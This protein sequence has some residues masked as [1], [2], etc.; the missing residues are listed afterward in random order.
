M[1]SYDREPTFNLRPRSDQ[2]R[3][4]VDFWIPFG[5]VNVFKELCDVNNPLGVEAQGTFNVNN[6]DDIRVLKT[7]HERHAKYTT[8]LRGESIAQLMAMEEPRL[9]YFRQTHS[10]MFVNLVGDAFN[11]PEYTIE[12]SSDRMGTKVRLKYWFESV[13]VKGW[14]C[15][16]APC[17]G[18]VLHRSLQ[19]RAA[20]VWHHDMLSRGYKPTS[21]INAW[22]LSSRNLL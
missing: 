11:D 14:L 17:M 18:A 6:M 16:V 7:G 15:F 4:Q 10:N 12:L 22:G 20:S 9:L 19:A 21:S 3:F 5:Q 1:T 8:G 2:P 13:S